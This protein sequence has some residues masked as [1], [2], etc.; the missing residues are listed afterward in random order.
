MKKGHKKGRKQDLKRAKNTTQ[1]GSGIEDDSHGSGFKQ[2]V[3]QSVGNVLGD[4]REEEFNINSFTAGGGGG[5]SGEEEEP[6][7]LCQHFIDLVQ[8]CSRKF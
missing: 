3:M 5:R 6:H 7:S 1:K 8:G 2:T 4:I